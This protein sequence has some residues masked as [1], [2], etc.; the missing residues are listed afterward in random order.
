MGGETLQVNETGCETG[1][2]HQTDWQLHWIFQRAQETSV[3]VGWEG[4]ERKVEA[5]NN[6]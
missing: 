6:G 4:I 3:C 5:K 1:A 2:V